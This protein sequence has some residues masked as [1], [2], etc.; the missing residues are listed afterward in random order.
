[1][2]SGSGDIERTRSETRTELQTDGQSYSNITLILEG[3]GGDI[4][5][6]TLGKQRK[7]IQPWV[8]N[9]ALDLCDQRR[10]LRQQKFTGTEAGLDY[11]KVN[12]EVRKKMKA[13]S[14]GWTEEQCKNIQKEMMSGNSKE[15]Y[16]NLEALAKT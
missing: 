13:A 11:R 10:Q 16:N 14:Q 5:S 1:M 2:V 9:E 8:T 12:R 7:K 15:V 3:G 4:K 6:A